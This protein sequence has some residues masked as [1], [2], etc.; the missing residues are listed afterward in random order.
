MMR[1]E[2][3]IGIVIIVLFLICSCTPAPQG[4][5][6]SVQYDISNPVTYDIRGS[7]K[8]DYYRSPDGHFRVRIPPLQKSGAVIRDSKLAPDGLLVMFSDDFC[9]QFIVT[10]QRHSSEGIPL[11]TLDEQR[12]FELYIP[13]GVIIHERRTVETSAGKAI[14]IRYRHPAKAP[15]AKLTFQDGKQVTSTPD[16][17]V[18]L[19]I[20]RRGKTFYCIA[21]AVGD[22]PISGGLFETRRPAET[23]EDRLNSFVNG[24][25]ILL[26]NK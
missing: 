19:Y 18:G 6:R 2:I 20:I 1:R 25:E 10:A 17:E 15:C 22:T 12:V 14:M 8:D 4:P 7:V 9:R 23:I 16:A 26:E 24:F 21:Y 3:V 13:K 5:F 11:E